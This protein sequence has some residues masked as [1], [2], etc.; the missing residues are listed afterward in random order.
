MFCVSIF[1]NSSI[2]EKSLYLLSSNTQD[3]HRR[4]MQLNGC[5]FVI[6][7][8]ICKLDDLGPLED[9]LNQIQVGYRAL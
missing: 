2:I 3:C 5:C 7:N 6:M 8:Y 1:V 9:D 4:N